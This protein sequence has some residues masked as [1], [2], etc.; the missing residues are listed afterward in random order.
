MLVL[1]FLLVLCFYLVNLILIF[2]GKSFD[3]VEEFV[4]VLKFGEIDVIFV[5]MYLLL[6]CLDLFNGIW[7]EVV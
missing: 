7:F 3:I 5:D 4:N 1:Y 2:L 6:K